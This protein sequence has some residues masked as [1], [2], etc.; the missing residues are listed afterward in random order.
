M[1]VSSNTLRRHSISIS[2]SESHIALIPLTSKTRRPH[3]HDLCLTFRLGH[4]HRRWEKLLVSWWLWAGPKCGDLQIQINVRGGQDILVLSPSKSQLKFRVYEI[5][6][7]T[8]FDVHC[9][10]MLRE[11]KGDGLLP[12]GSIH[13]EWFR[14]LTRTNTDHYGTFSGQHLSSGCIPG[15]GIQY[16]GFS[17][18]CIIASS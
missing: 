2:Y 13:F 10:T 6:E 16:S 7:H 3:D 17:A 8:W 11:L 5:P 1:L 4:D 15:A 9:L 12:F 14:A 18:L